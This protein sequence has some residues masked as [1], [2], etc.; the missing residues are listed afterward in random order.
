MA[1]LH[2]WQIAVDALPEKFDGKLQNFIQHQQSVMERRQ[3]E[4]PAAAS[5][6][7]FQGTPLVDLITPL[8]D[9]Y[10]EDEELTTK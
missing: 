7:T 10:L 1:Q 9:E 5:T 6:Q 3:M 8:C 2:A 4:L